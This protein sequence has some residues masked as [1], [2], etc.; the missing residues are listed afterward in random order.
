MIESTPPPGVA[1]QPGAHLRAAAWAMALVGF[2]GAIALVVDATLA[3]RNPNPVPLV[4]AQRAQGIVVLRKQLR[5]PHAVAL[6]GSSELAGFPKHRADRFFAS[7][8]TGFRIVPI[9]RKAMTP[10]VHALTIQALGPVLR[11]RPIVVLLSAFDAQRSGRRQDW[12]AGNFSRLHTSIALTRAQPAS[13]RLETA[14]Q[15]LQYP[16]AL[17]SDPVLNLV[18]HI[19]SIDAP[20]STIASA[21]IRP[22]AWLDRGWLTAVDRVMGAVDL[23]RSQVRAPDWPPISP[24]V[25]WQTLE[26]VEREEYA[27]AS[28]SNPFGLRDTWWHEAGVAMLTRSPRISD[29]VFLSRLDTW[30]ALSELETLV[31]SAK[32][33]GARVLVIGIPYSG[34]FM[35]ALGIS[36]TAR[37]AAYDR[38][39]SK[40]RQLGVLIIDNREYDMD[41]A[42]LV[43]PASHLSSVG[44]LIVNRSINEFVNQD[45]P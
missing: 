3:V 41:R 26:R 5:D 44:W 19:Q 9:G 24:P 35:D 11:G 21:L 4:I 27:R 20:L 34:L 40:A 36:K 28:S 29:S 14:I 10:L 23:L 8:P 32:A 37:A 31:H 22:I 38:L 13:L 12:F 6:F 42:P 45:V 2:L 18:A 1:D 15:L 39:Q 7:A 43:D 25:D 17:E 33:V 30:P 16:R